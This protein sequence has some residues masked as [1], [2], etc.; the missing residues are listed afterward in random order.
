MFFLT[1]SS[2]P[3]LKPKVIT[4]ICGMGSDGSDDRAGVASS[5]NR[6]NRYSSRESNSKKMCCRNSLLYNN[7]N[8]VDEGTKVPR[9]QRKREH[10]GDWGVRCG[11][12]GG[13]LVPRFAC[14]KTVQKRG[15]PCEIKAKRQDP[16]IDVSGPYRARAS[17]LWPH[18]WRRG[19]S[20]ASIVRWRV[21][22]AG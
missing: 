2:P 4:L 17:L 15:K 1:C 10:K 16:P 11:Q 14:H 3:L 22:C 18:W 9:F 6:F 20:K 5:L 13:K 12:N 8:L 19:E 7:R 21:T